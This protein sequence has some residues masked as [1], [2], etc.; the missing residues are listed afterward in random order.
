MGSSLV[1]TNV[2]IPT[3]KE[4]IPDDNQQFFKCM[5]DATGLSDWFY[6]FK[7]FYV[8]QNKYPDVLAVCMSKNVLED[9]YD[10]DPRRLSRHFCST[11]DLPEL[12]FQDLSDFDSRFCAVASRA[13]SLFANRE[14][15]QLRLLRAVVPH[16]AQTAQTMNTAARLD[17]KHSAPRAEPT[18]TLLQRLIDAA[19]EGGTQVAIVAMGKPEYYE[20]PD[21]LVELLASNKVPLLDMRQVDGIHPEMFPD[22]VHMNQEAA[23][24][25]SAELALQLSALA[26]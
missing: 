17:R 11:A 10:F 3:I 19:N 15:L 2:D 6:M 25:L 26:N 22:E 9:G 12:I 18:Y 21:P 4:H 20:L 13:S 24:L 5:A 8:H 14:R 1:R 23:K 7:R 16:Y